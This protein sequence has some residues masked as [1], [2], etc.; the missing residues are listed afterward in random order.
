[1]RKLDTGTGGNVWSWHCGA[2][3]IEAAISEF[4][5]SRNSIRLSL[6]FQAE[7]TER[8]Q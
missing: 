7:K 4:M 3:I 2:F 8:C 1:M 5:R 6:S